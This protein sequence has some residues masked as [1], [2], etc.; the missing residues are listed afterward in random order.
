MNRE[1]RQRGYIGGFLWAFLGD[2][3]DDGMSWEPIAGFLLGGVI[4]WLADKA[5]S[6]DAFTL[7]GQM[8][9][10][11]TGRGRPLSDTGIAHPQDK[12]SKS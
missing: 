10:L 8:S 2:S 11:R 9:A 3:G 7:V 4:G 6:P 12:G 5:I 1:G